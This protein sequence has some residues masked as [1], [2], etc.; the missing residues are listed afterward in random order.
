MTGLYRGMI[1][2]NEPGYYEDHSFGIRIEVL[3]MLLFSEL[4]YL[5]YSKILAVHPALGISVPCSENLC[6]VV[7]V[8]IIPLNLLCLP[9]TEPSLCEGD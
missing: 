7:L 1:V 3:Y 9:C 2:S 8:K 6:S 4:V 5:P